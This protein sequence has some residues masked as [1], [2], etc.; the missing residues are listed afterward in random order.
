MNQDRSRSLQKANKNVK[1]T[2]TYCTDKP[3]KQYPNVTYEKVDLTD[4]DSART[5]CHGKSRVYMCAAVTSGAS[6]MASNPMTH[7][8]PNILMNAN[9]LNAAYEQNVQKYCFISSSVVYPDSDKTMNEADAKFEF[10]NSYQAVAWMK[11]FAEISCEIY[12]SWAPSPMSTIVVR[13]SN[14]YGPHDKF[15][16][17]KAKVIP[18]LIR[19]SQIHKN[20]EVWGDGSEL[21]DF[22]Y[23]SDFVEA[24][25]KA[26]D[27]YDNHQ[28]VNICS[29]KEV[30]ILEVAE[31]IKSYAMSKDARFEFKKGMPKMVPK[32]DAENE[33]QNDDFGCHF[34]S[35][36]GE[37]QD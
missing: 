10:F 23:I 6:V 30:T 7:F 3:K 31:I 9:M 22:L 27:H 21:K 19:K 32:F 14:L 20:L 12:G 13:P 37:S 17:E 8:T 4:P 18:S 35:P 34:D 1:I 28:V 33:A 24:L 16:P 29:G 26:V 2:G 25:V 5:I 15:D 11:R 36:G